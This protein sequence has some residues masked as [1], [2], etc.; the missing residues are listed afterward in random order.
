MWS[1][2]LSVNDEKAKQ[3]I[4]AC[5][6]MLCKLKQRHEFWA[7]ITFVLGTQKL[8]VSQNEQ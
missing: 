1:E 2:V 6:L 5:P 4:Q 7:N 8:H 3:L